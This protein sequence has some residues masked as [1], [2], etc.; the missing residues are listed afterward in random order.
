MGTLLVAV[1]V[2]PARVVVAGCPVRQVAVVPVGEGEAACCGLAQGEAACCGLE[3][4]G[5]WLRSPP[6]KVGVQCH[7]ALAGGRHWGA[8][9]VCGVLCGVLLYVELGMTR[10][11]VM[12]VLWWLVSGPGGSG[13][14]GFPCVTLGV[15]AATCRD[16]W[17]AW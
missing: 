17:I 9:S 16:G 4:R 15:D 6:A 14:V 10:W 1:A 3:L 8:A 5:Y 7:G 12:I 2:R 11:G 13:D